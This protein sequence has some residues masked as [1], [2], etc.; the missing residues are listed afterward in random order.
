VRHY[1][2]QVIG[3]S[4]NLFAH[5]IGVDITLELMSPVTIFVKKASAVGDLSAFASRVSEALE[6]C[7]LTE[8]ESSN[9]AQGHYFTGVWGAAEVDAYYLDTEGLEQYPFAIEIECAQENAAHQ[10]AQALAK[11]GL[12]CFI[13]SGAW[14]R[15]S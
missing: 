15:K 8:R 3:L 14:Y 1:R 5:R 12:A 2:C 6:S 13:P 7:V 4:D 10:A 9:Y 11:A